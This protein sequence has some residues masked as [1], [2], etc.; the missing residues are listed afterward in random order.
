MYLLRFINC[1]A[2]PFGLEAVL[3]HIYPSGEEGPIEFSLRT[4]NSAANNYTTRS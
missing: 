2:S 4:L 1:D 3:S